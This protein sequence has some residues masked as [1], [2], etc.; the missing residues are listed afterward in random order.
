MRT[1]QDT[2]KHYHLA[3]T[4]TERAGILGALRDVDTL[5][6][7]ERQALADRIERERDE[8]DILSLAASRLRAWYYGRVRDLAEDILGRVLDGSVTDLQD[9]LHSTIDG[10]DLIIY[11]FKAKCV[12]LASDN[13]DAYDEHGFGD[14]GTAEARAFCALEV[15]VRE[16]LRAHVEHPDDGKAFG[17]L[18]L[19]EG[20]DLDDADTWTAAEDE[21]EGTVDTDES[22]GTADTDEKGGAA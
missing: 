8:E 21:S 7:P 3:L 10:T 19:P 15:D 9:E 6:A 20:F 13:E 12:L 1:D 18:A 4:E 14:S 5:R 17:T 16:S 22:D 11:T 2:L